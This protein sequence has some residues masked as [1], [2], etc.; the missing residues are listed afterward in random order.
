ME[1][2]TILVSITCA[3][4]VNGW[5]DKVKRICELGIEEVALFPTCL[6]PQQRKELYAALENSPIKQIPHV[7]LRSDMEEWELEFFVKKYNTQVFNIHPRHSTYPFLNF[8]PKYHAITFL[9]NVLVIP[10]EAELKEFAGLCVDFS[11]WE[12]NVRLGNSE[13]NK[14]ML[15][16]MQ[17][18]PIGCCHVSAVRQKADRDAEFPKRFTHDQ[19][20]MEELGDLDYIKKYI[21]YL[22]KYISIELENSIDEQV[23]AKK[24]LEKI[25]NSE[26]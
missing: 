26:N 21:N 12:G 15:E 9:E 13:Y 1:N 5:K 19:H 17:K 25:I 3:S 16:M 11:H 23:K 10:E 7:H 8:F 22:P 6:L 4:D 14:K 20:F 24:Y 2:K 18:F